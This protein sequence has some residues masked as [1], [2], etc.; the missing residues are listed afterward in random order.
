MKSSL[1]SVLALGGVFT[2]LCV[3]NAVPFERLDKTD[4]LLLVLDLQVGL[5]SLVRD[6]DPTLYYQ[7]MI[8]H[9]AI[10]QYVDLNPPPNVPFPIK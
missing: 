4:A 2:T 7:N 1:A 10:G 8:A 6:F 9:A 3:A 5:Y